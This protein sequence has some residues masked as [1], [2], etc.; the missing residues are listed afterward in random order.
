M[1]PSRIR[2]GTV[3]VRMLRA[4]SSRSATEVANL[5]LPNREE[6]KPTIV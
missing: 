1:A 5:S 3:K 6:S 2:R 4:T